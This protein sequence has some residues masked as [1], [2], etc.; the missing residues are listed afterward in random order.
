MTFWN[1]RSIKV[2][3]KH[4]YKLQIG[5]LFWWVKTVKF[6]SISSQAKEISLGVAADSKYVPGTATV[7]AFSVTFPD[8]FLTNREDNNIV[9][10]CSSGAFMFWLFKYLEAGVKNQTTSFT[11]EDADVRPKFPFSKEFADANLDTSNGRIKTIKIIKFYGDDQKESV[12]AFRSI[13]TKVDIGQGDY[14]SEEIN[15]ITVDFQPEGLRID[16]YITDDE[17]GDTRQEIVN[18]SSAPSPRDTNSPA[19]TTSGGSSSGR[20]NSRRSS[21]PQTQTND[22]PTGD[23]DQPLW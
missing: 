1:E 14:S 8:V 13:I 17:E 6:P 3:Q 12:L 9:Y 19:E 11:E 4:R 7:D 15:E 5:D 18:R 2:N 16:T 23:N 22:A 10:D 20:S 21:T